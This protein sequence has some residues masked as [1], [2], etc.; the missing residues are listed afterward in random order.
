MQS[1]E[2]EIYLGLRLNPNVRVARQNQTSNNDSYQELS[3]SSAGEANSRLAAIG[4]LALNAI[5]NV[6][7]LC[8]CILLASKQKHINLN[9]RIIS[10]QMILT[11]WL[12]LPAPERALDFAELKHNLCS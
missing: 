2:K 11:Y 9:P 8:S 4:W 5:S 12:V 3:A 1:R 6:R 7:S 10:A